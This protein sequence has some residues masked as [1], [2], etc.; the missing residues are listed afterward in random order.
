MP[1]ICPMCS[2]NNEDTDTVCFVCDTPKPAV[3]PPAPSVCTLTRL[4]T[5][6]V[7][8]SGDIT[9]PDKY[10]VIG[11]GAFAGCTSLTSVTLHAGVTRIEKDAFAGCHALRAVYGAEGLTSIGRHAF[12]D[13]PSLSVGDRPCAASTAANAFEAAP[14]PPAPVPPPPPPSPT[15]APPPPPVFDPPPK[16]KLT[17]AT[18]T[19]YAFTGLGGVAVLMA[20]VEL[21]SLNIG[22]AVFLAIVAALLFIF[23]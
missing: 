17:Y 18:F 20:V 14:P 4:R 23:R 21:F 9:V 3:P 19:R 22:S 13:C 2:T 15:P 8:R 11:A 10:N 16:K 7:G 12:Y 5:E 6:E 1:W